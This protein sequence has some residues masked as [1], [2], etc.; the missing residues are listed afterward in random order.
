[1]LLSL[2]NVRPEIRIV[3][4]DLPKEQIQAWGLSPGEMVFGDHLLDLD[5]GLP[6]AEAFQDT[7]LTVDL[8]N[9]SCEEPPRCAVRG[10]LTGV[11]FDPVV[12]LRTESE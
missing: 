7:L 9:C 3:S 12:L 6:S 1:M 4:P 11:A 10:G 2:W 8:H 5:I